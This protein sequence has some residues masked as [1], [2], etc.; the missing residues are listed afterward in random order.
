MDN[1]TKTL[2]RVAGLARQLPKLNL[3][4]G[5][6]QPHVQVSS[7]QRSICVRDETEQVLSCARCPYST[8][9]GVCIACGSHVALE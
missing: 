1:T 3:G 2:S 4:L 7:L 6:Q 9:N 8:R 5:K